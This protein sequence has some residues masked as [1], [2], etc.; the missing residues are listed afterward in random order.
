MSPRPKPTVG[1]TLFDLNVGNAARRGP[2]VLTKVVVTKVGRKYFTCKEPGDP[3]WYDGTEYHLG[4]WRER[5][6]YSSE[7]QLYVSEQEREDEAEA[8]VLTARLREAIAGPS[9]CRPS[10]E[11]LR[12]MAAFLPPVAKVAKT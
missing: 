1:Q 6:S 11:A 8:D 10:L 3:A 7:H 2:Q 9:H 4:D 5:T 12:G